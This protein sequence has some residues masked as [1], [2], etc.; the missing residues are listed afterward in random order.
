MVAQE[1]GS[2]AFPEAHPVLWETQLGRAH[3]FLWET[4]G[5]FAPVGSVAPD[6]SVLA[7]CCNQCGAMQVLLAEPLAAIWLCELQGQAAFVWMTAIQ[8]G[9]YQAVSYF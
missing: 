2:F 3:L 4:L 9:S 1:C 5:F 7:C 8:K 6:D